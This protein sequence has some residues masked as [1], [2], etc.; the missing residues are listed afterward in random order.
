[1]Q[2]TRPKG[3]GEILTRRKEKEERKEEKSRTRGVNSASSYYRKEGCY[4]RL[5]RRE[6]HL[7]EKKKATGLT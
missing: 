4:D 5:T 1:M 2:G 7:R 3:E 6:G